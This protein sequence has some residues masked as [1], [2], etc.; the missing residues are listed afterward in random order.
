MREVVCFGRDRMRRGV[1]LAMTAAVVVSALWTCSAQDDELPAAEVG[2]CSS[3]TLTC[4]DSYADGC[5][6]FPCDTIIPGGEEGNIECAKFPRE[7]CPL[8]VGEGQPCASGTCNVG[9]PVDAWLE[10]TFTTGP[11]SGSRSDSNLFLSSYYDG[12]FAIVRQN[13]DTTINLV[14]VDGQTLLWR[15]FEDAVETISLGVIITSSFAGGELRFRLETSD[16]ALIV[17]D[18]DPWEIVGLS[19]QRKTLPG[20]VSTPL[21]L[22][23]VILFASN[24]LNPI[25]QNITDAQFADG[26]WISGGDGCT[27]VSP[28]GRVLAFTVVL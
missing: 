2:G 13:G 21:A 12:A 4:Y 9:L 17:R 19:V 25:L 10:L 23:D 6:A 27:I 18:R 26:V 14:R 7:G 22:K 15:K 3:G 1:R 16:G 20:P 8:Y 11:T 24:G 28:C 5:L